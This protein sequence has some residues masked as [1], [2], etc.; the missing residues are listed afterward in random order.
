MGHNK[1]SQGTLQPQ[2][3]YRVYHL[4]CLGTTECPH[5]ALH[6]PIPMEP[7][8]TSSLIHYDIR[9]LIDLH[10]RGWIGMDDLSQRR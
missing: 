6:T 9:N 4:T 3:R 5:I 2:Y 8:E 10:A 7:D 1:L